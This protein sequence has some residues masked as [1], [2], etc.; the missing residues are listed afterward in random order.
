MKVRTYIFGGFL[1]L[2]IFYSGLFVNKA[3]RY[4]YFDNLHPFGRQQQYFFSNFY[5][6][7]GRLPESQFELKNHVLGSKEMYAGNIMADYLIRFNDYN[8]RFSKDGSL[9]YIYLFGFN[10]RDDGMEIINE[11]FSEISFWT[12]LFYKGDVILFY[13]KTDSLSLGKEEVLLDTNVKFPPNVNIT[14]EK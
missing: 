13:G 1:L 2:L 8:L 6:E 11:N 4:R 14:F 10:Y 12:Y 3:V 7:F 9:I 5:W